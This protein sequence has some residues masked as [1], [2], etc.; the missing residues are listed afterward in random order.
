[1]GF[2]I[3]LIIMRAAG[4]LLWRATVYSPGEKAGNVIIYYNGIKSFTVYKLVQSRYMDGFWIGAGDPGL[5]YYSFRDDAVH[6]V[7]IFFR[8]NLLLRYMIFM[9]K[10][11]VYLYAGNGRCPVFIK[12]CLRRKQGLLVSRQQKTLS[13]FS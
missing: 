4:N 9:K 5:F 12:W 3:C 6:S 7:E 10:M 13:F 2:C 8:Y 1:M 11:I